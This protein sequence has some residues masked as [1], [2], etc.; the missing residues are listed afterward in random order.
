MDD[1][2]LPDILTQKIAESTDSLSDVKI[3]KAL[4][5]ALLKA[6]IYAFVFGLLFGALFSLSLFVFA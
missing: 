6:K 2:R 4:S 5:P 3:S 1:Q